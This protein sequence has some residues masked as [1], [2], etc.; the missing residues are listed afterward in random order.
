LAGSRGARLNARMD[1]IAKIAG[2]LGAEEPHKRIAAAVVLGELRPKDPKVVSALIAMAQEP[3][4]PFANAALGALGRIGAQQALPVLIEALQRGQ[5]TRK[6]AAQALAGLGEDALPKIRERLENAAP[7]V[8]ALVSQVL[9]QMGGKES[10]QLALEGLRGQSWEAA[11]RVALSV[12][13]ELRTAS[14]AER[15]SLRAQV[16]KF[17]GQAKTR[18]DEP[19]L[20]AAIKILGYFESPKDAPTLLAY[21]GKKHALPVRI[22]AATAVRFSLAAGP[23]TK[24]LRALA[25][26]LDDDPL[27]ARSARDTLMSLR[28][29]PASA[30]ELAKLAGHRDAEIASFSIARLGAMGGKVA[31]ETLAPIAG[32]ADRARAQAAVKALAALEGGE[33]FLL[34]ALI[35]ADDEAGAQA[36]ADA[37]MPLVRKLASKDLSKLE[38][39]AAKALE[40]SVALGRRKLDPLR[41]V[42]AA[43]WAEVIR[44]AAP[45]AGKKDPAKRQALLAVLAR[46]AAASAEDRYRYVAGELDRPNFDPHPSARARDPLLPELERLA[47]DGFPL[48]KTLAKDKSVSP[49]ALH[50]LGFHFAEHPS[51]DLRV[52]G[53]ELLEA[54]VARAG[55]TKL[56]KAAKNKLA[57]LARAS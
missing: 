4:E 48:A 30:P 52:V 56:G 44:E 24:S 21:V 15:S 45:R 12:R 8:R 29:E 47:A 27:L 28:Y 35:D 37:L 39:A 32:G 14:P 41:E 43:G 22:E 34:R 33:R 46:S 10:F 38:A 57:L 11:N 50:Y 25:E 18:D 31:E 26:L 40:R 5:E 19:A 7:E 49:E 13:Q 20:R 17:L 54:V 36:V 42:D 9:P 51:A 55:R 2:L 6:I 53:E 23:D 3:L 16:E 1:V